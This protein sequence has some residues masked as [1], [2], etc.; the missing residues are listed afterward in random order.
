MYLRNATVC[1]L[2]CGNAAQANW[3]ED[4]T[5]LLN[6]HSDNEG[7]SQRV[8]LSH[9]KPVLEPRP[10]IEKLSKTDQEDNCASSS[11]IKT[12]RGLVFQ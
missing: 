7:F 9:A 6:T 11:K 4:V 12:V 3:M 5:R 10:S 1:K 2:V 8:Q